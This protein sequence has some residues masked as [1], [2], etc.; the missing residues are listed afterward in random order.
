[1]VA[2]GLSTASGGAAS[3]VQIDHMIQGYFGWLGATAVGAADALVRSVS[4]EH[5]DAPFVLAIDGARFTLDY[6][7][8]G[9][10]CVIEFT[11]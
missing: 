5:R 6:Q 4:K 7:P 8:G 2:R 1:M 10:T 3:P 9:V 11:A